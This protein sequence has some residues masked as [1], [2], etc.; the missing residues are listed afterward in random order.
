MIIIIII[1]IMIITI[2]VN[3]VSYT[4]DNDYLTIITEMKLMIML[5][6]AL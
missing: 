2:M 4:N 5:I 1:I 6:S 3:V